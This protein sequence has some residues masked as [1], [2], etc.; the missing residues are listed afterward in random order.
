[1]A[2]NLASRSDIVVV[3]LNYR[4]GALGFLASGKDLPGNAGISD[5]ILALK[6]VR[7]HIAAFG[8]DPNRITIGGESAGRR[9]FRRSLPV[10][11]Q[12]ACSTVL[13]CFNPWVPWVNRAA[14]SKYILLRWQPASTAPSAAKPWS[15]VCRR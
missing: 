14:Q 3:T 10:P 6:W 7:D 12:R 2:A 4:L 15:S 5:Q 11:R 1:M 8:G 13:S 9:V